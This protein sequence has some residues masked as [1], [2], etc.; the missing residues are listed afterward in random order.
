MYIS[1]TYVRSSDNVGTA[2]EPG[3]EKPR[4]P[5]N[6]PRSPRMATEKPASQHRLNNLVRRLSALLVGWLSLVLA[7]KAGPPPFR[8]M[9]V[10]MYICMYVRLGLVAWLA[11]WLTGCNSE[12]EART[13]QACQAPVG[14]AGWLAGWLVLAGEAAL[15]PPTAVQEY[16]LGWLAGCLAGWLAD[17]LQTN[18]NKSILKPS[19]YV[20]REQA[21][22]EQTA[23]VDA[24]SDPTSC[25]ASALKCLVM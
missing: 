23:G 8:T 4:T 9:Y 15:R 12:G 16:T 5:W 25:T 3:Q 21:C 18:I 20:W 2:P 7:G 22:H 19:M 1:R 17:W 14:L 10:C 6:T 11:G 13:E 24:C